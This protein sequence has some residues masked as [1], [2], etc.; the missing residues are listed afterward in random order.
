MY[1]LALEAGRFLYSITGNVSGEAEAAADRDAAQ[2]QYVSAL[3]NNRFFAYGA[4]LNG[5]GRADD[6]IFGG[7]AAGVFLGRHAGWGD[8]GAPF[9]ATLASLASQLQLQVAPSFSFFAP[10]V[11]NVTAGA[12][13]RDPNNGNP[14]S[15]WPFYLESYTGT[16]LA[17]MQAGFVDDGIAV[18]RYLYLVQV[19]WYLFGWVIASI[20]NPD[21][22]FICMR[23]RA[24]AFHG[25]KI[26]GILERSP[27]SQHRYPG[28][29]RT[30]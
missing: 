23:R 7:Q 14:S 15:T 24:W 5:S 11:F 18:L 19:I 26:C 2:E 3:F 6:I 1:P 10:K 4:Q 22:S 25:P 27:T 29:S 8:I 17:A 20:S 30:S 12:R 16:A 9:N 28:L 13:A 21:L